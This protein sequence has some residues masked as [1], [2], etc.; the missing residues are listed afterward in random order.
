MKY[1][2]EIILEELKKRRG[3]IGGLQTSPMQSLPGVVIIGP[4]I[5][6]Q[7]S[8]FNSA[9]MFNRYAQH[10]PALIRTNIASV[11]VGLL[12]KIIPDLPANIFLHSNRGRKYIRAIGWML[13]EFQLRIF[14][15]FDIAAAAALHHFVVQQAC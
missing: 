11:P 5:P 2:G 12:L 4:N 8:S 15:R 1:R 13:Q 6:V 10:L 9:C 14:C 3:S 7:L